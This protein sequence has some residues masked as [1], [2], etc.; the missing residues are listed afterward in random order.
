MQVQLLLGAIAVGAGVL[1]GLLL[2]VPFVALSYRRRGHLSFMR[3]ALWAAALVYF[4]AIW[5][6]TL[7]P[8]PDPGALVCVGT[9]LNIGEFV[10]DIRRAVDAPGNTLT[11]PLVLQLVLNVLLFV[12]LGFFLRVLGNRGIFVAFLVG[13]ALSAFIETTQLTGVWGLY[14]CAYRVFD[15]D[16][17]L[18]N[19]SGA[20][21]GSILSLVVPKSLRGS[22]PS[23]D[24]DDPR[25]VTRGRRIVAVLC[26]VLFFGTISLFAGLATQLWVNYTDGRQAM[27]DSTLSDTISL[28]VP[29]VIVAVV[30]LGTGRSIGDLAVQLNWRGERMPVVLR[31]ILRLIGGV[32][33]WLLLGLLPDP[34]NSLQFVFGALSLVLIFT[35]KNGRGLPGVL[36]G[37]HVV[38]ARADGVLTKPRE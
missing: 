23:A 14:P 7:L 31:R 15:V 24:A 38:D 21:L 20:V 12:P 1:V 36:S 13:F 17:M 37:Q 18:T 11:N 5:T 2:F 3:F 6:Y 30:T 19:T 35:T 10:T 22:K 9:N 26:D 29:L 27:L 8:L 4:L 32:S 33:G 16:D 34:W 25:P 28:V